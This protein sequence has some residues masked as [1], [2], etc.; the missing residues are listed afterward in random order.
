[1]I[2]Y[3]STCRSDF[4]EILHG[5][6]IADPYRWMEALDATET[7]TWVGAQNQVTEA[8]L[9]GKPI[10]TKIRQRLEDVWNYER[11]SIPREYNGRYF[12]SR[13]NGL[14]NQAVLYWMDGL[15]GEP[16]ELLDPNTLSEDGTVALVGYNPSDD[17]KYLAYG[18][19]SAGSDWQEWRIRD[20]ETGEDLPDLIGWAK[21]WSVSWTRDGAGFYYSRFDEPLEGDELKGANFFQKVYYHRMGTPQ[22][23]D[24][25]I[26]HR[27]D[28]KDWYLSAY[29]TEDGR[30]LM[31]YASHGTRR[32]NGLFY[33]DLAQGIRPDDPNFEAD[34]SAENS[35]FTELFNQFDASYA[36]IGNDERIFYI[37]TD[38]DAPMGRLVAV[39]LDDPEPE[40]WREIIPEKSNTLSSV[41]LINQNMLVARYLR[42]ASSRVEIFDLK[43]QRIRTVDLP[44]IGS[45]AGFGGWRKSRETF[46]IYSSFNQPGAIYRYD[47]E[48]GEAHLFHQPEVNFEPDDYVTEQRFCTSKDGTKVPIFL[49]YKKDLDRSKPAP[50]FLYGYGGFNI[51]LT[52]G[53]TARNMVWMEMGGIFVQANLRGGGE[54]GQRWYKAGTKDEKQNVFDDFIAAAEDLIESGTTSREKLAIGGGS[55]GGLLVGACMTQRPDLFGACF[56]AVGVMDM[57][58]FHKFTLGWGWISDYG[59]PDIPADFQSLLHYSPYHN[60]KKG[61]S[62]PPTLITT[63]DHDDRVFPAHSFKFAAA[64]QHANTGENPILIRIAT[65]AGHGAGKPTTMQIEE[66]TDIW[67]FLHSTL[68]MDDI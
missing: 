58:R 21:T 3:P 61:T 9:K 17:G 67:T 50:T 39:D 5:V 47:M 6:E 8:F 19:S 13:N 62:Y 7:Q 35:P 25:L 22:S 18:L 2:N 53:F 32:E 59:D 57:L 41:S 27:P 36:N 20:V 51:A 65:K 15:S 68:N 54:Y 52:P 11:V 44:G 4:S 63:G 48:T 60:V 23:E 46:Y 37:R 43:G 30:F 31:I 55:N 64:L 38:R 28:H 34:G 66:W 49:T 1:M 24:T 10:R 29:L 12:F 40:S 56:A 16:K 33:L 26:Y 14:Q 42:D 45:A